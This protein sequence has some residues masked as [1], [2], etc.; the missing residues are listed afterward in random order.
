MIGVALTSSCNFDCRYCFVDAKKKGSFLDEN[1]FSNFVDYFSARAVPGARI[2][3]TGGEPTLHPKLVEFIEKIESEFINPRIYLISNG[4]MPEALLKRLLR[5]RVKFKITFEGT[6]EIHDLERPFYGGSPSSEN[7]IRSI[8]AILDD[9]PERLVVEVNHSL[10]KA[11]RE[12]EIA[13]F[14]K[15]LGVRR[16]SVGLLS[17]RGRGVSYAG[18]DPL[19]CSRSLPALIGALKDRGISADSGKFTEESG[20]WPGCSGG[21]S[22]FFL[23]ADGKISVCQNIVLAKG[24]PKGLENF[25]VGSAEKNVTIFWDKLEGFRKFA[26]KRF[27]ECGSCGFSLNCGGCPLE[28]R[29]KEM[30][31]REKEFCSERRQVLSSFPKDMGTYKINQFNASR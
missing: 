18:A 29:F 13:D 3:F 7:V 16:V 30:E 1:H 2:F 11:G 28:R 9:D 26:E 19:K 22:Y 10:N 23:T 17:W 5:T 24:L 25:I 6:P 21:F 14:L 12:G 27:S 15:S 31:G 4:A 8:R 20:K